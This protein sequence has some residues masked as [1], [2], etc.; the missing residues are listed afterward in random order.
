MP[1][2]VPIPPIPVAAAAPITV[3]LPGGLVVSGAA[4]EI[5]ANAL[6]QARALLRSANSALAPLGPAFTIIDAILAIKGFADAVP[7]L[8][9]NPGAVVEAVVELGTKVSRLAS[10]IPQLSVPIMVVGLIDAVL[11][12]LTGLQAEL[13][14]IA[15]QMARIETTRATAATLPDAARAALESIAD[16]ASAQVQVQRGDLATALSSIGP[17]LGIITTFASLAGVPGVSLDVDVTSGSVDEAADAL[18]VAA[19]ALGAIRSSIP[20]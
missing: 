17:V 15:D 4:E 7:E 3:T 18:G 14:V 8:V 2:S 1:I 12:L 9:V 5:G 19:S 13:A 20:V 10:L 11:A 6:A 16:A